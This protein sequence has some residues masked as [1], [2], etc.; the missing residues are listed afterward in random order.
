MERINSK[1]SEYGSFQIACFYS[2]IGDRDRAFE[3]LER[4]YRERSF[5]IAVLQVTPQLDPLRDD[6]RYAA[7]L[8]QI[9]GTAKPA[10]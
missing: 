5:L 9:E 8:R 7:L 3:H 2:S 6:P 10:E 1:A 4:A